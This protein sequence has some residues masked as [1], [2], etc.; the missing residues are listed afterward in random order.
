MWAL[1]APITAISGSN[2]LVALSSSPFSVRFWFCFLLL[3]S[4]Y[5]RGSIRI[6]DRGI[7]ISTQ[8]RWV[9]SC[10]LPPFVVQFTRFSHL[11]LLLF[12]SHLQDRAIELFGHSG[13]RIGTAAH[14]D[15]RDCFSFRASQTCRNAIAGNFTTDDTQASRL[16]LLHENI[17]VLQR[18]HNA[19]SMKLQPLCT[20]PSN[21]GT[22]S[23]KLM[24]PS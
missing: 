12:H 5:L 13:H 10:S 11:L 16:I 18:R 9:G 24:K 17:V 14:E 6:S 4:F 8:R 1:A 15:D 20:G 2:V 7:C 21:V 19:Y 23:Q 22:A 3:C